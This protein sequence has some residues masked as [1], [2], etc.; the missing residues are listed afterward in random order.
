MTNSLTVASLS[1]FFV[2]AQSEDFTMRKAL[3]AALAIATFSIVSA[4]SAK[5]TMAQTGPDESPDV[6]P[7]V[8]IGD[9]NNFS[10][11]SVLIWPGQNGSVMGVNIPDQ[12]SI[13][14]GGLTNQVIPGSGLLI[15]GIDALGVLIPLEPPVSSAT[16]RVPN[17]ADNR[18]PMNR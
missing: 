7:V 4:G 9:F 6:P 17:D 14:I 11:Q 10:E 16:D 2:H 8:W 5:T 15:H 1:Q 13:L 12:G 18:P 3:L